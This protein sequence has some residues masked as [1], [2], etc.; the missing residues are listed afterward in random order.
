MQA[1]YTQIYWAEVSIS[2]TGSY[3]NTYCR[4]HTIIILF[5][6]ALPRCTSSKP[7]A[8]Q[9]STQHSTFWAGCRY[10]GCK[11]P[12]GHRINKWFI[13]DSHGQDHLAVIGHEL[14][15]KDGNYVYSA[16]PAFEG[17]LPLESVKNITV[18]SGTCT[19]YILLSSSI[20]PWRPNVRFTHLIKAV[21]S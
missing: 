1:E 6:L 18:R 7:L 17:L 20:L 5:Y 11:G 4:I 21:C 14:E 12:G 10:E 15:S 3:F 16:E 19:V 2:L 8:M 13:Q 9:A